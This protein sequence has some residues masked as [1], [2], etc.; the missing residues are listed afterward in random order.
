MYWEKE[1][2]PNHCPNLVPV[3]G[4][5]LHRKQ[6]TYPVVHNAGQAKFRYPNEYPSLIDLWVGWNKQLSSFMWRIKLE[7]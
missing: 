1:K 3:N 6:E 7:A 4:E 5:E 2:A